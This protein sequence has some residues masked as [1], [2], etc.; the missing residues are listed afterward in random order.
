MS[1]ISDL[2][3]AVTDTLAIASESAGERLRLL[4]QSGL[5]LLVVIILVLLV[6]F[7]TTAGLIIIVALILGVAYVLA[8]QDGDL[9]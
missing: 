7:Q 2:A 8:N 6:L 1:V 3:D 9:L 5:F 4:V